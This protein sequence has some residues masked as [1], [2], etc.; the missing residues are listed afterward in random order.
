MPSSARLVPMSNA[1]LGGL[2]QAIVVVASREDGSASLTVQV[3]WI[4]S[5][6]SAPPSAEMNLLLLEPI[7]VFA[8]PGRSFLAL[9]TR[10]GWDFISGTFLPVMKGMAGIYVDRQKAL[11]ITPASER[12]WPVSALVLLM[13]GRAAASLKTALSALISER[14]PIGVEVPWALI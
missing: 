3:A 14:S 12:P 9:D 8:L 13:A 10:L 2:G 7:L 4:R 5:V 11:S 1:T 6:V